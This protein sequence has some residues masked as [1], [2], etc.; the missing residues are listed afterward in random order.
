MTCSER[1]SRL[2]NT[3]LS[4]HSTSEATFKPQRKPRTGS[5]RIMGLR[6]SSVRLEIRLQPRTKRQENLANQGFK[7]RPNSTGPLIDSQRYQL[8][9]SEGSPTDLS[10]PRLFTPNCN[11]ILDHPPIQSTFYVA[12]RIYVPREP[13]W[14]GTNQN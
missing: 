14:E 2:A 3:Q 13:V 10:I 1:M 12:D 6:F 4:S 5:Y 7:R 9:I 11:L 8:L